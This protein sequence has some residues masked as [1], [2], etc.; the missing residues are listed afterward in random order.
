M[1]RI[2]YV[3]GI[4]KLVGSFAIFAGVLFGTRYEHDCT[5]DRGRCEEESG[6][7]KDEVAGRGNTRDQS[8]GDEDV[9]GDAEERGQLCG[10]T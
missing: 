1:A 9:Q 10:M 8:S 4:E 5:G 7:G 6:P 3:I 2:L